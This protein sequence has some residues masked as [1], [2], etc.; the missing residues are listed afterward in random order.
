MP[1]TTSM[2]QPEEERYSDF[3]RHGRRAYAAVVR[4]EKPGGGSNYTKPKKR[5]K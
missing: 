3:N 2:G 4:T 5:R 1:G